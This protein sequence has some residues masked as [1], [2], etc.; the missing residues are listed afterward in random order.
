MNKFLLV[1]L[2]L[3]CPFLA[4]AEY[5]RDNNLLHGPEWTVDA[6]LTFSEFPQDSEALFDLS[7]SANQHKELAGTINSG[8]LP[9]PSV[10]DFKKYGCDRLRLLFAIYR[11]SEN[12]RAVSLFYPKGYDGENDAWES[13]EIYLEFLERYPLCDFCCIDSILQ[14]F[15]IEREFLK[16]TAYKVAENSLSQ[17]SEYNYKTDDTTVK[18]G[19]FREKMNELFRPMPT[20]PVM[21][22]SCNVRRVDERFVLR[23]LYQIQDYQLGN[24]NLFSYWDAVGRFKVGRDEF[25]V[26]AQSI[27]P[28]LG[29]TYLLANPADTGYPKALEIYFGEGYYYCST[30]YYIAND[31]V[32]VLFLDNTG[33]I[34]YIAKRKYRLD[35]N[36]TPM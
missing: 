29:K 4:K 10:F 8:T 5:G 27:Y 9:R 16:L 1:L 7:E 12:D 34:P 6:V 35:S 32:T 28:S 13:I 31:I 22:D 17:L 11:S 2:S 24:R 30:G 36:F 25:F 20:P 19:T 15:K 18:D 14:T 21:S 3:L 33:K 23:H 26:L